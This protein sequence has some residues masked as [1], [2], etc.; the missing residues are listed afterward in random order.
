MSQNSYN[1]ILACINFGAPALA[2]ALIEDLNT[3]INNSN[4][5]IQAQRDAKAKAETETEAAQ[6]KTKSTK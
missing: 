4:A 3:V 2:A 5:Y 6:S 1:T